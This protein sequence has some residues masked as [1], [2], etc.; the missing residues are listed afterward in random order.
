MP[1]RK[2]EKGI[3]GFGSVYQRGS[4]GRWVAKYKA[5]GTKSGYKE[6]Y[7]HTDDEA[8]AKLERAWLEHKQGI[9]ATGPNQKVKDYIVQ[10]FE[11]VHKPTIGLSSYVKYRN[12]LYKHIIP[13]LGGRQIRHVTPQHIQTF[14]TNL[15]KSGLSSST[16][17]SIHGLL[18]K[19]FNNAVTW[20]L[21]ARNVFDTVSLPRLTTK[22]LQLLSMEQAHTLLEAA[23]EHRL[24][25]LLI[26]VLATGMRH[27]EL[28]G[29]RWHDI[30]FEEKY[31]T[32]RRTVGQLAGHGYVER[33]PKTAKGRR[34]IILPDFV[35]DQLK[36][37]RMQQEEAKQK[38]ANKWQ[39]RGLV[40]CNRHG[41]FIH[42]S[43]TMGMFRRLLEKAKL[44]LDLRIHDLR[45]SAATI[46]LSMGIHP[47]IV[48]ELLGHSQISITMDTY[49]HVMPSMQQEAMDKWDTVFT[50]GEQTL[51]HEA[52][53]PCE[54]CSKYS[55]SL[56]RV[57]HE[58]IVYINGLSE[59]HTVQ[60]ISIH[61]PLGV[62]AGR[63]LDATGYVEIGQDAMMVRTTFW[64]GVLAWEPLLK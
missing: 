35:I 46:F 36:K 51:S 39:E 13:A 2:K 54:I 32:V 47:K 8:Y 63:H 64:T 14:Y 31:L 12:I 23:K 1:R 18:H 7:A 52:E 49:S 33:E 37:H 41:G 60:S 26:V 25:T 11:D 43:N 21:V 15:L 3:R 34:K 17:L 10:W 57:L 24:E 61:H 38:A 62:Q 50:R 22:E 19:A 5:E 53:Q 20:N 30:N 4:D 44:P 16:V 45:H 40:F 55:I 29:L 28:R 58:G 9:L 42:Q 56:P 6:E 59:R 27:G 48:Q